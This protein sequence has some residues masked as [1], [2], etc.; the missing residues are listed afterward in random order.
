MTSENALQFSELKVTVL[1][2]GVGGA[3]MVVGVDRA[4]RP[5]DLSVVVNTGDDF[6]HFGLQI[7][8]DID[9][10]CYTLAGVANKTYGWGLEG[11]TWQVADA[12][13]E[14]GAPTW[15][16]LGDRDLAMHMERTRLLEHGKSLSEVVKTLSRRMG[17]QSKVYPM[18]DQPAP[19]MI[20]TKQGSV[21]SFQDYLVRLAAEPEV[22]RIIHGGGEHAQA[23]PG[24]LKAIEEAD[25]VVLAPSNPWV[26]IDPILARPGISEA[27]IKQTVYAVSPII[28]GKALKGPA[29]K[30]FAE[31][32]IEPSSLA[33]M[34]HYQ[35][36]LD[37]FVHDIS[38]PP[39]E[40]NDSP[41]AERRVGVPEIV[42][43]LQ[44]QTIMKD[45]ND[46][47]ALA[48]AICSHYLQNRC[49]A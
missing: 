36:T 48:K 19:T 21:L 7:C 11:E 35:E 40:K 22:K 34:E 3:K 47:V 27:L 49:D 28:L 1:A 15:F 46:K 41:K 9:S 12:L 5:G 44:F 30:M 18:S 45:E 39:I 2:G 25:F 16:Q 42:R 14:L 43:T 20:E 37:Y 4:L 38:E 26:S 8:P 33:V 23:L 32:G 6:R 31:L 13:K 10:V 17:I 24:A 29:A